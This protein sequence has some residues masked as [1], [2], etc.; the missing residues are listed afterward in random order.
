MHSVWQA[1]V[2]LCVFVCALGAGGGGSRGNAANGSCSFCCVAGTSNVIVAIV[3][4]GERLSLSL[5]DCAELLT[6]GSKHYDKIYIIVY[7][8]YPIIIVLLGPALWTSII[9]YV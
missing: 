6:S 9:E 2:V 7:S 5:I 4:C 8:I 3:Y 1:I